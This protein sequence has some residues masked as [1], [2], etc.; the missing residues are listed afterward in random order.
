MGKPLSKKHWGGRNLFLSPVHYALYVT[1]ESFR[2]ELR[3]ME[4]KNWQEEVFIPT[5]AAAVVQSFK[6]DVGV[7]L[8][9]ICIDRE[10]CKD[11]DI[12]EIHAIL[13]HEAVHVWQNIKE[14]IHEEKPSR[15]FEA[16]SIQSICQELF[17]LYDDLIANNK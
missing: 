14:A 1:E 3:K 10:A 15:E 17:Y 16:H 2:E 9:L 12:N 5:G 6:S 13:C 8:N 11:K 4:Y 7:W